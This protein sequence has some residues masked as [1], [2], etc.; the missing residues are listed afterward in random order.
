MS[1]GEQRCGGGVRRGWHAL[2]SCGSLKAESGFRQGVHVAETASEVPVVV[3]L[4][5]ARK[6]VPVVGG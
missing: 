1:S 6:V 5:A 4:V 3:D 2:K